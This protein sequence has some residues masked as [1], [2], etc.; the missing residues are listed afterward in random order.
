MAERKVFHDS[1]VPIPVP[2]GPTADSDYQCGVFADGRVAKVNG[3][4][5]KRHYYKKKGREVP[6][7]VGYR[8]AFA[9][10]CPA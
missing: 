9:H 6:S 8:R 7:E 5:A 1:I 10:L 4:C 3:V 2:A